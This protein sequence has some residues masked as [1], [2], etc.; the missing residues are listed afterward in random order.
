[1]RCSWGNA[2][3]GSRWRVRSRSSAAELAEID[4]QADVTYAAEQAASRRIAELQSEVEE[5]RA[6]LALAT[7]LYQRAEGVLERQRSALQQARDEAQAAN[8]G[9]QSCD[10]KINEIESSI[11]VI[12]KAEEASGSNPEKRVPGFR[13]QVTAPALALTAHAGETRRRARCSRRGERTQAIDEERHAPA[14][15]RALLSAARNAPQGTEAR[16]NENSCRA[17]TAAARSRT[18]SRGNWRRACGRAR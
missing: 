4:A 2:A 11:K 7:D 17:T 12:L 13:Q 3:R 16:L 15:A 18:K 6:Q 5:L 1:M 8:F 9:K 14:T 10:S